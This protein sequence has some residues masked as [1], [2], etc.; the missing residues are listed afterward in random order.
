M[1]PNNLS[2]ELYDREGQISTVSTS[3][4]SYECS[5]FLLADANFA[6]I[7]FDPSVN[8]EIAKLHDRWLGY[9][10]GTSVGSTPIVISS[11]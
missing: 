9:C 11:R 3:V 7:G 4:A 8:I 1:G 10:H 6:E 2:C 5:I